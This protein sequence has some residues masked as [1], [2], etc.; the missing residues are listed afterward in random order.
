MGGT[1]VVRRMA[2]MVRWRKVLWTVVSDVAVHVMHNG[3][4]GS[5]GHCVP[6]N[7]ASA[8]TASMRP[9]AVRRDELGLVIGARG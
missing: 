9:W 5:A 7:L 4:G 2:P 3:R 6:V 8:E 1:A